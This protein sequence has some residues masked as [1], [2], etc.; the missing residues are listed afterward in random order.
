ITPQ[1]IEILAGTKTELMAAYLALLGYSGGPGN[2]LGIDP[3]F[4]GHSL[5]TGG[6]V[7]DT[8]TLSN[9]CPAPLNFSISLPVQGLE[10]LSVLPE[11]GQIPANGSVSITVSFDAA[12][13]WP[14][15]YGGEF[16]VL[17]EDSV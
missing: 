11:T 2:C 4:L 1:G 12:N 8:L 15:N 7:S 13:I 6:S 16:F 14:G 3:A 10:W 5:P 17:V 9:T